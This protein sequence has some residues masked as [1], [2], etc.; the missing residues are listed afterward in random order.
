M[1]V[2]AVAVP[3]GFDDIPSC[4]KTKSCNSYYDYDY[5]YDYDYETTRTTAATRAT[6]TMKV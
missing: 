6:K 3:G 2:V 5:D 4:C 1:A